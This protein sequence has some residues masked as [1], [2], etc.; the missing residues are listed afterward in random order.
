MLDP[1]TAPS[2]LALCPVPYA[3]SRGLQDALLLLL[4]QLINPSTYTGSSLG[5]EKVPVSACHFFRD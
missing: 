2:A 4:L 5:I 1:V 3:A